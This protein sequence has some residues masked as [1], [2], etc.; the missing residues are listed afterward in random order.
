MCRA[1]D[2][3]MAQVLS[4]GIKDEG[5]IAPN[6]PVVSYQDRYLARPAWK[7]TLSAYCA[8]VKAG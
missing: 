1:C 4:A 7:R 3:L 8:R 5:L 6:P 2:I